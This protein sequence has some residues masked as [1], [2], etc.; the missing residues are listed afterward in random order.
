MDLSQREKLILGL[1][2]WTG[3]WTRG[4]SEISF[5]FKYLVQIQKLAISQMKKQFWPV[6]RARETGLFLY[7]NYNII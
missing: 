3:L 1:V 6:S 2:P 4:A 5:F 7:Q